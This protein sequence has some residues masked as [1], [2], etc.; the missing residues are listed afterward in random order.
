[1]KIYKAINDIMKD[2][3]AIKKDQSG[4]GISYKYR[5]IEQI[6]NAVNP[7]LCKY[8]VFVAPRV[9]SKTSERYDN[10]N[11]KITFRVELTISHKFYADDGSFV[12]VEMAGEGIDQSDKATNKATTAAM[13]YAFNELFAIT[14][15]DTED[16]DKTSPTID[17]TKNVF[18]AKNHQPDAQD[19][20]PGHVPS[21]SI[22]FGKFKQR[23]LEEVPMDE[24]KS[25]I[26]Y[27]EDKAER[28]NKPIQGQ[29]KE[30]IDRAC[31]YI[32]AF[33][34]NMDALEAFPSKH[35]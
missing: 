30:F 26:V 9:I 32:A 22:P 11:G 4:T 2:L 33:E 35:Y 10:A 3:G 6:Y 14:T 24:L 28:D 31:S 34:N 16:S 19:G 12:E 1:M 29:V 7:L 23:S 21:Y 8:G 20:N 15:E 5:G 17:S 27:I 25:Y 13:K 18:A